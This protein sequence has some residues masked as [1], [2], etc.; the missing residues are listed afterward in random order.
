[1]CIRDS[2][3]CATCGLVAVPDSDL[4][5]RLPT[6][7]EFTGRGDSPLAHVP[8][9]VTVACPKCGEPARRE[10]DTMDTFVD[11]SWYYYRFCDPTNES[12]P[13]DPSAVN[14]WGPVDFYSGGVEHA[15]LHLIYS[16]FFSRV[17]RDVGLVAIDEPFARLLTQ[18]MVLRHGAVMSKSKGNVVDPDDM[19]R[20]FGADALRLY[21]MFVAPPEK[22]VE[23]T[24]TGLE[25]SFRFLG[26]VWRV[27]D[28]LI[29]VVIGAPSPGTLDLDQDER[30]LRRITH[31]T[32]DRVTR[33]IDPRMHLNTAISAV[34]EL[35]NE[36][37][38]FGDRRGLK[39]SGREDAPVA[40]VERVE[41]AAV[42]REAIEA[43]ILLLSPFTPHVCEELWERLGHPEGV[44]AAGWPVADAAA[45]VE[46][47]VE[48]PVQING[49]LRARIS[50][51]AGQ[52]DDTIR[53]AALGSSV[54]QAHLVGMDVIRI[55]VANGRLVSVVVKP[56]KG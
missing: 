22:E 44:V 21:V 11:S 32:I 51:P 35:V 36:L 42:L 13:F 19:I 46:D 2:V 6:I 48:I 15:I 18:G 53:E 45:A 3:T 7:T 43:V 31:R 47:V 49:K 9:F 1:M 16:R 50:L 30:K 34:M 41:S 54:V 4:P 12:L 24:D 20:T 29:P 5:V 38:A 8:E 39:P 56:T 25:G 26:R 28:Y 10:T 52:D 37:Y 17:F 40:A 23:W 14:Y 27:A 33:D 55:V